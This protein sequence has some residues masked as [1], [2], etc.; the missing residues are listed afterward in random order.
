M[1]VS[2][3]KDKQKERTDIV[4]ELSKGNMQAVSNYLADDIQ[5]KMVGYTTLSGKEEVLKFAQ[6]AVMDATFSNTSFVEAGDQ[7]TVEGTCRPVANPEKISAEYCDIY[8]F[9]GDKVVELVSYYIEL[10]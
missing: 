9:K 2:T 1:F 5:W 7:F 10:E 8:R 3:H 4:M 6:S